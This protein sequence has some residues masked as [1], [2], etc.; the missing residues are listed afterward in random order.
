VPIGFPPKIPA[1]LPINFLNYSPANLPA[2]D[3]HLGKYTD[4]ILV[5][6][7]SHV[8]ISDLPSESMLYLLV[9]VISNTIWRVVFTF[10]LTR[11][12]FTQLHTGHTTRLLAERS[13]VMHY[14]PNILKTFLTS[15]LIISVSIYSSCL[16]RSGGWRC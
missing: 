14:P 13:C 7:Q 12:N 11:V 16:L 4:I 1:Y 8:Y 6:N 3:S 2:T 5:S 9:P 10:G 15:S